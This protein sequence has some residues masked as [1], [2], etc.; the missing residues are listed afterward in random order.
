MFDSR[1]RASHFWFLGSAAT[2]DW[3][4][5]SSSDTS[6]PSSCAP[7]QKKSP[8]ESIQSADERGERIDHVP[9]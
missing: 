6:A 1:E 8:K 7:H 3:M 2:F 5:L 4:N 9:R